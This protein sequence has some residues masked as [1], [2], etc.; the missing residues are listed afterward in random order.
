MT[1]GDFN[2]NVII[3]FLHKKEY[4]QVE[5]LSKDS[6]GEVLSA[7]SSQKNKVAVKIIHNE[8]TWHIEEHIWPLLNHKSIM[9]LL[10]LIHV[11]DF[12]EIIHC[13]KNTVHIE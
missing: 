6:F 2:K 8:N 12:S 5:P 10:D 13:A 4:C 9:P 3:E 7:I 11:P 1:S